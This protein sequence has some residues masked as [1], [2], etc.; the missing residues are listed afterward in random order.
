MVGVC[1]IPPKQDKE[2]DA[3][4]YKEMGE[5]SQSPALV[6]VHDFDLLDNCWKY[7]TAVRKQSKRLLECVEDNFQTQLVR[8]PA[9]E[10]T[11]LGLFFVHR[12]GLAGDVMV[13]GFIEHSDHKKTVF[14]SQRGRERGLQSGYLGLSKGDF[15]LGRQS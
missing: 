13:R 4:F 8:D 6:L 1:Y 14:S 2:A 7:N 11:P 9:R 3:I 10:G 5:V 12:E 15:G